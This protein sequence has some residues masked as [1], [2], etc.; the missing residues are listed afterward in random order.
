MQRESDTGEGSSQGMKDAIDSAVAIARERYLRVLASRANGLR[1]LVEQARETQGFDAAAKMAHRLKGTAGSYGLGELSLA[2]EALERALTQPSASFPRLSM[3]LDGVDRVVDTLLADQRAGEVSSLRPE[4]AG[5]V[6]LVGLDDEL[7]RRC[8]HLLRQHRVEVDRAEDASELKQVVQ[9]VGYIDGALLSMHDPAEVVRIVDTVRQASGNRYLPTCV[10]AES[11]D[12]WQHQVA[13]SAGVDAFV[14][15]SAPDGVLQEA[16]DPMLER[17]HQLAPRLVLLDDDTELLDVLASVLSTVGMRTRRLSEPDDVLRHLE[18]WDPDALVIDVDMPRVSGTEVCSILRATPRFQ[19]LPVIMLTGRTDRETRLAGYRVGCDDFI[20]KPFD[21]EELVIR[22][23][24]RV[25]RKRTLTRA[26]RDPLSGLVLRRVFS[27]RAH[28]RCSEARRHGFPLSLCLLDLDR[29]KLLNDTYG[30]ATGDRVIAT[31]GRLLRARLREEDLAGRWGG[32]EFAIA[33]PHT[34]AER[35]QH[36]LGELLR[37]FGAMTFDD[38]DGRTFQTSFSAGIATM[39]DDGGSVEELL[40]IAD[41]R[42]YASKREGRARVSARPP[43]S[44]A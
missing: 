35:A 1:K 16:F 2:F 8:T 20:T 26:E 32:E 17:S 33:L 23:Q 6:V 37:L 29:F 9:R 7:A 25:S 31:L 44:P 19:S 10:I 4:H 27:M 36:V 3:L 15:T 40:A 21:A 28:M 12:L 13:A 14:S 11:P 43:G 18:E 22:I 24:A 39:P 38:D 42:L 30:H 34:D 5:R 41:A